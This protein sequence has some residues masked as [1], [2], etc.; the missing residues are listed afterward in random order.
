MNEKE[1]LNRWCHTVLLGKC[2]HEFAPYRAIHGQHKCLKD[3]GTDRH[4]DDAWNPDY[5]SSLDLASIVEA[6]AIE[7][8]GE[9]LWLRAT[10]NL[11]ID[12]DDGESLCLMR[13]QITASAET[14]CKAARA[15]VEG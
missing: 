10:I 7:V 5:C 13:R 3:C 9:D 2:W 1:E 8:A 11:S 15:A 6:K 14:R 4:D 12:N